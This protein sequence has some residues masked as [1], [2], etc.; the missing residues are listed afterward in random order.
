MFLHRNMFCCVTSLSN[1]DQASFNSIKIIFATFSF[2]VPACESDK[3]QLSEF[4]ILN[5]STK[6]ILACLDEQRGML[7]D[8]FSS[9]PYVKLADAFQFLA[10][11]YL[12][13]EQCAVNTTTL[14]RCVAFLQSIQLPADANVS[15]P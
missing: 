3:S 2:S 12:P 8:T 15:H 5:H 14:E 6:S 1:S 7:Y 10:I 9:R 11:L 4:S 13:I